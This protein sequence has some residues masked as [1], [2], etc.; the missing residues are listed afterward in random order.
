MNTQI[1]INTKVTSVIPAA[2]AF[3][4]NI[5]P[6]ELENG[7]L[8]IGI[9]NK[10]DKRLLNDI[11]FST[12]YKIKPVEIADDLILAKLKELYPKKSI[13]KKNNVEDISANSISEYSNIDLVNKIISN[14]INSEAS[15]IH[16]ESY[17]DSARIRLRI[18]GH[19][20][21]IL[22]L[23]SKKISPIIS[24]LKIMANLDISEKR[25]PQDGKISYSFKNRKVDIRVSTLPTNYGEK[26]VLRILD[27]SG[28]NI[29]LNSLGLDDFQV[30]LLSKY[31]N[32]PFGMLLVTGP[33]GSGKSTTLYAALKKIY[34]DAQNIVTIEDPIEYSIEGINQS[35]VK[36]EIGFDF[37]NAL[38]A[39][40]RQDPD[41]I[42]V[43]EIRDK[44]TAEIAIRAA[45]TGHLVLSTLHTN[46]SI[47]AITRLIDIGIEPYLVASSLKL[48]IA[49]R[50]VRKL[51][52]CKLKSNKLKPGN[53]PNELYKKNGCE[54]C[55]HTGYS[56]R[57]GLFETFEIDE[58]IANLITKNAP[59]S[60]IKTLAQQNGFYSLNDSGLKKI[61]IGI[62]DY[63]EVLRETLL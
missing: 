3:G 46:D 43:G 59:A 60:E 29:N 62:T 34:S 5:L 28:T 51:C 37:A 57:A 8:T 39:F 26:I 17:E 2:L 18:D 23:T 41:V 11:A 15:D 4:H 56:G 30:K 24:R 1:E 31:I 21:E 9:G 10:N 32:M 42:M 13:T 61:N 27:K 50:L 12:G 22:S 38:R 55:G 49:Q 14:A 7:E 35:S 48:V 47:S 36:P 44:E 54:E 58:K 52:K 19:L 45:L 6:I 20:R 33:T 25:R 40:L 63:E 16:I 53:S